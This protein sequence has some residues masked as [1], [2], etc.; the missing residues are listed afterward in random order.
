MLEERE[1]KLFNQIRKIR[2]NFGDDKC[3]QDWNALFAMLP[4]GYTP[5]KQDIPIQLENC[6]QYLTCQ[7]E[8]TE[9]MPPPRWVK[10]LPDKP[11][12]WILTTE[13]GYRFTITYNGG[14]LTGIKDAP[15]YCSFGPI[16]R[17]PDGLLQANAPHNAK[18]DCDVLGQCQ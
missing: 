3:W 16:P 6:K 8:G 7:S 2:D 11:G 5:P 10:G 17:E 12:V 15:V 1:D 9:Y 13:N 18:S 14:K 4:E